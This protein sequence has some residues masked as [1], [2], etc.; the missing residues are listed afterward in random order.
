MHAW[1]SLPAYFSECPSIHL[2]SSLSSRPNS[3]S[4]SAR[5][6]AVTVKPHKWT[7]SRSDSSHYIRAT[8]WTQW[9]RTR[10]ARHAEHHIL[11]HSQIRACRLC[12]ARHRPRLQ[13]DRARTSGGRQ[14]G[15]DQALAYVLGETLS[16]MEFAGRWWAWCRM[17]CDAACALSRGPDHR[18]RVDRSRRRR[19]D[20]SHTSPSSSSMGAPARPRG[21]QGT[22]TR[23]GDD[24]GT[25]RIRPR[26][27]LQCS[28]TRGS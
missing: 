18:V 11:W 20:R 5:I 22:D 17:H 26:D 1:M 7:V 10:A 28:R 19:G 21:E 12:R 24:P 2:I 4:I 13:A 6:E 3:L 27:G 8:Q 14:A 25:A 15:R 16:L 9:R 23:V